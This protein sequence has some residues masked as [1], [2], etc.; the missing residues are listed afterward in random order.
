MITG[1]QL[2]DAWGDEFRKGQSSSMAW[3]AL[4]DLA[5][6][7]TSVPR[8]IHASFWKTYYQWA[9]GLEKVLRSER[10][11]PAGIAKRL[12]EE[13]AAAC[14][15]LAVVA[16]QSEKLGIYAEVIQQAAIPPKK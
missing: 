12:D 11:D 15:R 14:T 10:V 6:K 16:Q 8:I 1:K 7:G 9:D 2:E 5:N 4:A 3:K 13:Y